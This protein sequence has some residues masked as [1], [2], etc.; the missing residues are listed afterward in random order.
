[1]SADQLR[2]W[3]SEI[4]NSKCRN[5]Q[6]EPSRNR[7]VQYDKRAMIKSEIKLRSTRS[8]FC[9]LSSYSSFPLRCCR[10]ARMPDVE[11]SAPSG[12]RPQ[13]ALSMEVAEKVQDPDS[14]TLKTRPWRIRTTPFSDYL[15]RVR[16]EGSLTSSAASS[17]G[18]K[19]GLQ[20]YRGSGTE[21]DPFV[22][23]L[24]RGLS[25]ESC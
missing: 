25:R 3:W 7:H 12:S 2:R 13:R 18:A 17:S 8:R 21:Q 23:R 6:A 9:C 16:F 22:V 19:I 11:K 14:H 5:L 15:K 24:D 10:L 20:N 1:M 4:S